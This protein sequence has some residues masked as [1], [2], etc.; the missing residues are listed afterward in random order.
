MALL[1]S[2]AL[3]LP[4]FCLF[5]GLDLVPWKKVDLTTLA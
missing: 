1:W 5:S 4:R 3:E 2:F